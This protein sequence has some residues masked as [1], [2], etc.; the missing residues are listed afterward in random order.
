MLD[1]GTGCIHWSTTLTC[2]WCIRS[3]A[4]DSGPLLEALLDSCCRRPR[5]RWD[6]CHTALVACGLGSRSRLQTH[7]LS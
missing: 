5:R 3:M 6:A 4:G 1:A 2:V 7:G